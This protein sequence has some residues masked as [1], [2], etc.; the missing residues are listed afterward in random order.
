LLWPPDHKLVP[1]HTAVTVTDGLSSASGF[2]LVSVTSNDPDPEDAAKDIRDFTVGTPDTSGRL[3]AE[4]SEK[5]TPRVYSLLYQGR[6]LAGNVSACT[7]T[8]TVAHDRKDPD[9]RQDRDDRRE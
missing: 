5:K 3:R 1:V 7:T 8:V 9:D 6:D 4:G 2:T